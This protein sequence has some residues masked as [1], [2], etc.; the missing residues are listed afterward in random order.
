[1]KKSDSARLLAVAA[2]FAVLA[3]H[4]SPLAAS[5]ATCSP[6][7]E[8]QQENSIEGLILD[9]EQEALDALHRI[10]PSAV[11]RMWKMFIGATALEG[12]MDITGAHQDLILEAMRRWPADS[13]YRELASIQVAADDLLS[14]SALIELLSVVRSPEAVAKAL[15]LLEATEAVALQ[16]ARFKRL[17]RQL[18]QEILRGEPRE[19][20]ALFA[21]LDEASWAVVA[22]FVRSVDPSLHP[23]V[24]RA[25]VRAALRDVSLQR[26]VL[27]S[28]AAATGTIVMEAS[29]PMMTLLRSALA[30]EDSL[31]RRMAIQVIERW[32]LSELFLELVHALGDTD[33]Q[34]SLLARKALISMT[35]VKSRRTEEAWSAW[36][37]E[38]FD[39]FSGAGRLQTDLRG[40][41]PYTAVQASRELSMHPFLVSNVNEVLLNGLEHDHPEVRI[42]TIQSLAASR[43]STAVTPIIAALSD[44]DDSVVLAAH[45]ALKQL[46]GRDLDAE[47]TSWD[48]WWKDQQS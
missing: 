5:P 19:R 43:H 2:W 34:V 21:E 28:L 32:G 42:A 3:A 23:A 30:S 12:K 46:S 8:V 45:A 15:G 47:R 22:V 20:Q 39:W 11:P 9:G 38:E 26:D 29:E 31:E 6:A 40:G 35:K 16:G 10:G 18:F 1:M 37:E 48:A 24:G 27:R 25:L 14:R 17:A 33:G 41:D 4:G 13:V 44:L 7:Q 36:Y